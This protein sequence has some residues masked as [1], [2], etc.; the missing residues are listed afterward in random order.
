[1]KVLRWSELDAAAQASW[2]GRRTQAAQPAVL[3]SVT[4]IIEQVRADGDGA[5]RALTRRFDGVEVGAL[6][7]SDFAD[8]AREPA[9]AVSRY[10]D[11]LYHTNGK[12]PLIA[13]DDPAYHGMNFVEHFKGI[14]NIAYI[15]KCRV[16]LLRPMG[17][18]MSPFNAFMFLQGMETLAGTSAQAS[19]HIARETG[20]WKKVIADAGIRLD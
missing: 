10:G 3:D 4:R 20:I 13:D 11:E 5:L 15:I 7:V 1:M 12:F 9:E 19:A 17:P 18:A 16:A 14:G 6:E 8:P 2:L